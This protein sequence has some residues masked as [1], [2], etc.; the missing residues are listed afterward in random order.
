MNGSRFDVGQRVRI[1]DR[2]PPVHHRVPAYAK[3]RAGA[4]ERIC[5]LHGQPEK[6]I[7]GDGNPLT[8]LYRVRIAQTQL[9][10]VYHGNPADKLELEVF[11]HWLEPV[12]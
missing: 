5:G 9:W 10:P 4:I 6:F 8:R 3:G 1:A 12:E 11:E 2:T 7:R